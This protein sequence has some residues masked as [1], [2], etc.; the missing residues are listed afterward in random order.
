MKIYGIGTDIIN[1]KRMESILKKKGKKFKNKY[2][3]KKEISYCEK[4]KK[5]SAFYAKRFAAKEALTKALGIGIGRGISIK[6]I[7]VS[8]DLNGKPY[9]KLK[10]K[11]DQ[12]LKKSIKKKK[13]N[14]FLSLSDDEPWAQATVVISYH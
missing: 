7:E 4:K 1:I 2:F 10:G 9:I 5:P 12:F 14:I 11:V 13:Y 6:N 3:S 8:N